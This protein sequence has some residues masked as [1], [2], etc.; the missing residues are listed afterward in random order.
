MDSG[1]HS[2][3]TGCVFDLLQVAIGAHAERNDT[4]ATRRILHTN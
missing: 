2:G 4:A 1:A 3:C